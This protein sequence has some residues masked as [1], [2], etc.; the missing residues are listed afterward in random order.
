MAAHPASFYQQVLTPVLVS[1][2]G[3]M[4]QPI[5]S[6][7]ADSRQ[8]QPGSLFC[9]IKGEQF[10]GHDFIP[11][12]L[13][14]G[15]TAVMLER[16]RALPPGIS[17]FQVNEPYRA[18]AMLAEAAADFPART[19]RLVGITGTN[20]KTTSAFILRQIFRQAGMNPAMIGTVIYDR[21]NGRISPADRTTPTPFEL[22]ELFRDCKA[23]QADPVVLEVSS[24]ALAQ[25]R[26]GTTPCCATLFTN[27]TRDHFDYHHDFENYFQAKKRLFTDYRQTGSPVVINGDDPYGQRLA[28]ELGQDPAIACFS[29]HEAPHAPI[30]IRDVQL[31]PQGSCFRIHRADNPEPWL[32]QTPLPGLFNVYNV[33]GAA[34]LAEAMKVPRNTISSAIADCHGAPGRMQRI[35]EISRFAVFVDYAH[36]DDALANALKTLRKLNPRRLVVVFGCGG[37]RDQTKRPMMARV[38]NN[39]A[40]AVVVTSDNPRQEK[41]DVIIDHI[42]AGMTDPKKVTAISDRRDAIFHALNC[43]QPGDVVLIAGKGHEDYQDIAGVKH[44]FSDHQVARDWALQQPKISGD[45]SRP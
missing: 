26:L 21:G 33:A 8:I 28:H 13:A 38:A 16:P 23:A 11:A 30:A 45:D 42:L 27:L 19:L 37:N 29:T 39:L 34:L 41:P 18:M 15:A 31:S 43:A 4:D 1:S 32:I 10:D 5:G 22:Q 44:P 12:A 7:S 35:H 2:D 9:A 6:V 40:D 20:G 25:H 17:R 3:P 36:T 14:A 24:H